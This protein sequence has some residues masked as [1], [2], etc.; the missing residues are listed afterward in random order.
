M[1]PTCTPHEESIFVESCMEGIN[2]AE[3]GIPLCPI[4]ILNTQ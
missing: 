4:L 2:G 3:I 1:K